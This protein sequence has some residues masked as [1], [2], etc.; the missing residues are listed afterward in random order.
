MTTSK[1]ISQ[2]AAYI[3]L[4]N[5]QFKAFLEQSFHELYPKKTF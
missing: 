2:E 3:V 5:T 4:L 1:G